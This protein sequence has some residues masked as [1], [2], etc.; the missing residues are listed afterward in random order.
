MRHLSVQIC[1]SNI[2]LWPEE[3]DKKSRDEQQP[4]LRAEIHY[5]WGGRSCPLV[6]MME[7]SVF[8]QVINTSTTLPC[9]GTVQLGT[10]QP[11]INF[12][13]ASALP[14]RVDYGVLRTKKGGDD[15]SLVASAVYGAD[16]SSVTWQSVDGF[17]PSAWGT[18][19]A[20]NRL[21]FACLPRDACKRGIGAWSAFGGSRPRRS[22]RLGQSANVSSL[23][24]EA[25]SI[26]HTLQYDLKS[27][28]SI[29]HDDILLYKHPYKQSIH[30]GSG[31][32]DDAVDE[33]FE[34]AVSTGERNQ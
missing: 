23:D 11:E 31:L 8:V 12:C 21:S 6:Q 29:A 24:Q 16:R 1:T 20:P 26:Q 9:T 14:Y 13:S 30:R 34:P 5:L 4:R 32:G 10:V 19:T 33:P 7:Y 3:P 2:P 25:A 17:V 22:G 27:S 28:R 15:M 18:C